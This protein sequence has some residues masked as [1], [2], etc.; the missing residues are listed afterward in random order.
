MPQEVIQQFIP[1]QTVEETGQ[2]SFTPLLLRVAIATAVVVMLAWGGEFAYLRFQKSALESAELDVSRLTEEIDVATI[3]EL[4]RTAGLLGSLESMLD[5]HV[6]PV[7]IFDFLEQNT[8]SVV[9]FRSF[10]FSKT[11]NSITLDGEGAGYSAIAQQIELWQAHPLVSNVD[12]H[13][14]TLSS[15]GTVQFNALITVK[16]ELYTKPSSL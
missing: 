3:Q 8:L 16:P 2:L 12:V 14:L 13:G 9:N 6:Y 5:S 7:S 4:Q 11:G 10:S 15:E 1:R